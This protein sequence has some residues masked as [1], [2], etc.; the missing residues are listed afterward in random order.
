MGLIR[1]ILRLP[2][3]IFL[4]SFESGHS[5]W[6]CI[7]LSVAEFHKIG[8]S[9]NWSEFH[10]EY[11]SSLSLLELPPYAFD[12]KSYWRSPT[13]K[14][15]E[16]VT[17]VLPL[18]AFL[19]TSVQNVEKSTQQ[20]GALLVEFSS[21]FSEKNLHKAISGHMVGGVALCPASVYVDIALTAAKY[22]LDKSYQES[23]VPENAGYKGR[24]DESPC[25]HQPRGLS[26]DQNNCFESRCRPTRQH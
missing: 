17:S 1:S 16:D 20:D 24:N 15:L 22:V 26:F 5:D 2:P 13:S 6:Q 18:A 7:S 14:K 9:I 21:R 12:L 23:I 3:S 19:G 11:K 25:R 8:V 4:S 10:R